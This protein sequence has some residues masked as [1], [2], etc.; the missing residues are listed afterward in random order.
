MLLFQLVLCF[1]NVDMHIRQ[2]LLKSI[3]LL[4]MSGTR[5]GKF[6]FGEKNFFLLLSLMFHFSGTFCC[7]LPTY[8]HR[9]SY[10]CVPRKFSRDLQLALIS[11]SYRCLKTFFRLFILFHFHPFH[12]NAAHAIWKLN[13][14]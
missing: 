10:Q 5:Y 11:G 8:V 7:C 6:T 9:F 4:Q 12:S 2:K 1:A 13:T 14:T 3:H